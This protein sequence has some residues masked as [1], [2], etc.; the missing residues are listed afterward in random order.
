MTDPDSWPS[1]DTPD[2]RA[3]VRTWKTAPKHPP[4]PKTV[5]T[6][7]VPTALL[8]IEIELPE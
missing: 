3:L 7:D 8:A 2:E 6:I 1:V 5:A 4:Q